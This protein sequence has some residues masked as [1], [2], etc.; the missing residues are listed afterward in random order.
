MVFAPD[1]VRVCRS[2]MK[3]VIITELLA[4]D[5]FPPGQVA[6]LVE[7]RTEN[8]RVGGS[9]PSLA[10]ISSLTMNSPSRQF[11]SSFALREWLVLLFAVLIYVPAIFS[12]P[13][14]QDD[15]D[16]VQATIARNML[17]SGDWVTPHLNHVA[18]MEKPPLKYWLIAVLYLIFGVHDWAAR[19]PL[20]LST[21]ALCWVTI[22]FGAWAYG[23]REGANAGLVLATCI[24]LFLFTRILIVEAML[25][26]AITLALWAML[27]AL[28]HDEPHP[29]RWAAVIPISMAL[30]VLLK[31]LIG[32]VFPVGIAI[33][34]LLLTR[35]LFTR[36][37]WTRLRPFSGALIFLIIAAP[38]HVLATLRNPPYFE[39]T[40]RSAPG[41]YHGFF[42][43]YFMNEHVLRFLGKRYPHDY[44]TVP[45]LLFWG[46]HLVWL[47][48]WS[49]YLPSVAKLDF[50]SPDRA[51]RVNL[52]ALCWIGFVLIFFSLS[53]TQEYYSVP[54]YPALALLL[55]LAISRDSKWVTAGTRVITAVAAAAA[56]TISLILA[57]VWTLPTPGDISNALV[58]HPE[59]Y[60]LSMGHM[61]DLT[62]ASFA[63]LRLPLILAGIATLIGAL[64]TWIWRRDIGKTS[65]A[66]ALMMVIFFHAARL[67]LVTFDPYLGSKP[68]ADA[69]NQ[70]PPGQLI[71]ADAYYAFSSVFY[72]A[73]RDALLLNGRTNNLEYGSYAPGAPQVF[74]GDENFKQLWE[75]NNRCYL[76]IYKSSVPD[77]RKVLGDSTLYQIKESGGNF[78]YTNHPL[79]S[80]S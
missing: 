22:R 79:T 48:P 54:I 55:G 58:Q 53:T 14:L 65:L 6:Q 25:T 16:A 42:W 12:P 39:F 1:I 72:Y 46:L 23:K 13:H 75:G 8:P 35:Q 80:G 70:S 29:R 74:I 7:Q 5:T 28:D 60:T 41:E 69:L 57:K 18:Y 44:N 76:V 9:I 20:I 31:G 4:F 52:L 15:V 78:L 32:V 50:K 38:W 24:G 64:G 40:F 45:R 66:A 43:F 51:S 47:F 59:M 11:A 49:F 63:Y 61:G 56:L 34:Y 30:A 67:A 26:L 2:E 27:R 73:D 19:M 17:T 71:E 21:L 62:L 77:V 3:V 68:L 10:T 33:V 36:A 37:T